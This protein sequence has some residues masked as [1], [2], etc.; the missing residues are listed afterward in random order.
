MENKVILTFPC[1]K[2]WQDMTDAGDGKKF[3]S[4][5][6]KCVTN[7]T[8]LSKEELHQKLNNPDEQVCGFYTVDQ[9]DNLHQQ[10][11]FSRFKGLTVSLLSL[12]GVFATNGIA[13]A[14]TQQEQAPAIP[15]SDS[16]N[17]VDTISFP[18]EISGRLRDKE[19]LMAASGITIQILQHG[20]VIKTVGTDY[21]GRFKFVLTKE[22]LTDTTITLKAVLGA[23]PFNTA[24]A[25]TVRNDSKL[26]DAS[27]DI[28]LSGIPTYHLL[29][30]YDDAN[31]PKFNNWGPRYMIGCA[32][33]L[34]QMPE[35]FNN[36]TLPRLDFE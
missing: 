35:P 29:N 31:P 24:E 1:S 15:V 26:T 14:Q 33:S 27:F 13:N 30:N 17:P 16:I 20:K 5:C 4:D 12:L 21:K 3:C 22:E 7:H 10:Y 18:V 23:N 19:T 25:M 34:F 2:K 28:L 8:G 9:L 32:V 6:N 11:F 36:T